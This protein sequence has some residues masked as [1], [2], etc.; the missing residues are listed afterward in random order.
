MEIIFL[1]TSSMVPTKERNHSAVLISYKNEGILVDCGEGTQRQMKMISLN[2]NRIT[3][4]LITHWHGDH[5]LGLPG[6][7]QTLGANEY[8]KELEIYG[9]K[10]TKKRLAAMSEAFVFEERIKLKVKEVGEGM[11]F[12][13][14]DFCLEAAK[15]KHGLATLGFNFVEKDKRKIKKEAMRRFGL[16]EGPLIGKLQEGKAVS[17]KNKIINPDDVSYVAKGK[18][19][20]FIADTVLC[21][22]CINLAEDADLLICEA[23]YADDLEDKAG[24]YKHLTAKHAG[25]VANKANVKKLV[26]THFSQRYKNTQQIEEDART[27]FD[28]VICAK[29]FMRLTL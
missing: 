9:P 10:D 20:T 19:V 18:K 21:N 14:E 29:D 23:T 26:L 5:V 25:L 15:L 24:K 4:V 17:W 11:F 12:E 8:Q 7:I 2:P 13:N 22:N 3:K 1:G 27:V 16:P 6:L 28:K